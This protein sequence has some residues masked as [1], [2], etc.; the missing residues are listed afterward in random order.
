MVIKD[1][2]KF[3]KWFWRVIFAI[4]AGLAVALLLTVLFTNIPSFEELED[5]QKN[6]ATEL[7]SEDGVILSTFH[8]QNR[9]Y[10]SYDEPPEVST[11]ILLIVLVTDILLKI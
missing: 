9:S 7:I 2:E 1:R 11:P 6:L 5:P 3:K 8:I 10:V 4:P